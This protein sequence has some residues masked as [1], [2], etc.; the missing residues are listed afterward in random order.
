MS[1]NTIQAKDVPRSMLVSATYDGVA[2]SAVLKFYEPDSKKIILWNDTTGHKPYC[3][4]DLTPQE[5]G[6][7]L[8][9]RSD[10]VDVVPFTLQDLAKDQQVTMT[11]IITEDPLAI[12][13]TNSDKSIRN[14]INTWESDIKYYENYLYD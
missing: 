2:K 14:V 3:Y 5:V 7:K 8:G 4:T 10:I 9:D 6:I 12:G 11:K 13:G 1:S